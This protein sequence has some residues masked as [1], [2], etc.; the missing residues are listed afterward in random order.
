MSNRS[1]DQYDE[2]SIADEVL[3]RLSA[4]S[5]SDKRSET[6]KANAAKARATKL[7]KLAEKKKKERSE[8][9]SDS[10]EEAIII[11]PKKKGK[12]KIAEKQEQI[13]YD[14]IRALKEHNEYLKKVIEEKIQT[15]KKEEPKKEEIKPNPQVEFIK[16][17]LI[18]IN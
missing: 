12:G 13:N 4:K 11:K 10:D 18:S 17:K 15:S 1:D 7:A 3:S 16:R 14:E 8:S 5:K 2:R 6:S 9:E